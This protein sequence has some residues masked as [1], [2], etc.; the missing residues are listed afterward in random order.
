LMNANII[1][2]ELGLAERV[3]QVPDVQDMTD[4]QIDARY[5]ELLA[6]EAAQRKPLH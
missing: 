1:A 2:R 6:K 5:Q 4:D 3:A